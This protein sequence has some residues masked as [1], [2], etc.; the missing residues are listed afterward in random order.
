MNGSPQPRHVDEVSKAASELEGDARKRYLDEHSPAA[1]FRQAVESVLAETPQ[2]E[3]GSRL[4]H[5]EIR[6]KIGSG[7]MGW[8]YEARD[9]RLNRV[10]AIKVLPPVAG[11]GEDS[12]NRLAREA[13]AASALNHPNIVTVYEIGNEGA[14][15][16]IA[17]ERVIGRT[18]RELIGS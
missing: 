3:P 6:T 13:Q 17:M 18:L 5:Y 16:Y 7:G 10:V 4:G 12:A 14:V 15:E 1:A 8:V 11:A 2:L 9:T